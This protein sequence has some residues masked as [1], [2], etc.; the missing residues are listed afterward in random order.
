MTVLSNRREQADLLDLLSHSNWDVNCVE[1][2][3]QALS[4]LRTSNVGVVVAQYQPS[5]DLSWHNLLDEAHRLRPSPRVIVTDRLADESTWAEVLNL[6]AYDLL[7]Q[8]FVPREVFHVVS[9]AWRSWKFEWNCR[10]FNGGIRTAS[11]DAA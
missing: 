2:F 6:G 3:G 8:P 9:C 11:P 5:G 10:H 1:T 4:V 7:V